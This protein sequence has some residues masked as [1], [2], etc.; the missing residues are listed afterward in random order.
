MSLLW[1]IKRAGERRP[2]GARSPRANRLRVEHRLRADL[3]TAH[4]RLLWELRALGLGPALP[5]RAPLRSCFLCTNWRSGSTHLGH[6]VFLAAGLDLS[7]EPFYLRSQRRL[8]GSVLRGRSLLAYLDHLKR[9]A[10]NRH[11]V[12]GTKVMWA[13]FDAVLRR[14][15]E[16]PDFRSLGELDTLKAVFPEPTFLFL[17]RTDKLRQAISFYR[18]EARLRSSRDTNTRAS[19]GPWRRSP[20]PMRPGATSSAETASSPWS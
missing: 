7:E 17:T 1:P 12:F 9:R 15:R 18:A 14:L 3:A 13:Q 11:G 10:T 19:R 8:L 2:R 16:L 4:L 20:W 6:S 5:S